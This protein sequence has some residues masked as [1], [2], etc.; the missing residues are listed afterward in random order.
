MRIS[1]WS[2]DVCSSDLESLWGIPEGIYYYAH[3]VYDVDTVHV[4]VA[5][6]NQKDC[7]IL[8]SRERY[9]GKFIAPND[10]GAWKVH[11][12][13]EGQEWSKSIRKTDWI[14]ELAWTS[15]R[16]GTKAGCT[17]VGMWCG[18]LQWNPSQTDILPLYQYR[19]EKARCGTGVGD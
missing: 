7:K 5:R 18:D 15:R 3:D 19:T 1:D 11:L 16:I 9:K 14:R 10:G 6:G 4:D 8:P 13:A 12:Q 2:S 17:V